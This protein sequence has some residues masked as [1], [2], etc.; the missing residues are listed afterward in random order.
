MEPSADPLDIL[1]VDDDPS[2]R[3]AVT[4]AVRSLGHTCRSAANGEAAWSLLDANPADVVITDWQM[5][6]LDGAALCARARAV[7]E[8]VPYTYFIL[9]TGV[10]DRSC[11][12]V[13]MAAGADDVQRKPLDLDELEARLMAAS[14]VIHLHRR[15]AAKTEGLRRDSKTFFDASRTDALTGIGNRYRMDE[16]LAAALSKAERYGHRYTLAICDVD[17]FK[18]YNDVFGHLSGDQALARV[19]DTIR[20]EIRSSD[21]V[22]RYGGE[23]F[24]VLLPEQSLEEGLLVVERVRLAVEHVGLPTPSGHPLT[25]SAGVA[26]LAHD[27]APTVTSWLERADVALYRAKADGRNRVAGASRR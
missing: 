19:A 12:R 25:I 21:A 14:R 6:G 16:E 3:V 2:S 13:G 27:T 18:H 8:D 9:M 23:E 7:D 4:R 11:L 24:V 26:E 17:E 1:V 22:F 10:D 5:P 20:R 15:L